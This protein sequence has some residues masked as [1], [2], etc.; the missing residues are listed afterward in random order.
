VTSRTKEGTQ[1]DKWSFSDIDVIRG[2][3]LH[4]PTTTPA[5]W[6]HDYDH[7]E[8]EPHLGWLEPRFAEHD[9]GRMVGS[10]HTWAVRTANQTILI[11][12]RGRERQ[13]AAGLGLVRQP[14]DE[15]TTRCLV[16]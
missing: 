6:F 2:E 15:L 5:D 3:E 7:P 12:H 10:V 8:L 4:L 16:R 14:G 13:V 1:V 11:R 9:S